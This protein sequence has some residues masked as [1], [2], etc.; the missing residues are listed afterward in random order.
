MTCV[1]PASLVR[2]YEQRDNKIAMMI[3][4]AK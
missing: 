1:K 4:S 2:H 3:A